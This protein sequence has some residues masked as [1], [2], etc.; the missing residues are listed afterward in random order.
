MWGTIIAAAIPTI[1]GI[2]ST[3]FSAWMAKKYP[4]QTKN[5]ITDTIQYDL[6]PEQ[7]EIVKQAVEN[8]MKATS[9]KVADKFDKEMKNKYQEEG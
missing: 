5:I 9:Y 2:A 8:R 3:W 1:L 7:A 4:N 6:K